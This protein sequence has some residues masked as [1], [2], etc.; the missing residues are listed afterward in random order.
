MRN[1]TISVLLAS[2][3][4]SNIYSAGSVSLNT[5]EEGETEIVPRFDC[6]QIYVS[7]KLK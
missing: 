1:K 2:M 6:S 7:A 4:I 3:R 5:A